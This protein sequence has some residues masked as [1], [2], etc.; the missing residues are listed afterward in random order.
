MFRDRFATADLRAALDDEH[1]EGSGGGGDHDGDPTGHTPDGSDDGFD[2]DALLG[3]TDGDLDSLLADREHPD[4][5][6]A[7][8]ERRVIEVRRIRPPASAGATEVGAMLDL[9]HLGDLP[10]LVAPSRR[11]AHQDA[12]AA[13]LRPRNAHQALTDAGA[14]WVVGDPVGE[15]LTASS[16]GCCSPTRRP[17]SWYPPRP[18]RCSTRPSRRSCVRTGGPGTAPAQSATGTWATPTGG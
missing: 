8:T 3:S 7:V 13:G 17:R 12:R 16:T 9:R 5:S 14:G 11:R 2:M 4:I 1:D 18:P 10:L 15:W 6:T